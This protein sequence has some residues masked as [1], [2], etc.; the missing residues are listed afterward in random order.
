MSRILATLSV[1]ALSLGLAN[2]ARAEC[3][4]YY[5]FE[6]VVQDSPV[7]VV[8]RVV[9]VNSGS[10]D[11]DVSWVAKGSMTN[12]RVRV[13]DPWANTSNN[14]SL[15]RL[16]A[17]ADIVLAGVLVAEFPR[18]RLGNVRMDANARAQRLG[19]RRVPPIVPR[20]RF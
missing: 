7:V 17:G 9:A 6:Q 15:H 18:D 12:R 1:I 19:R 11:L 4:V 8:G 20:A 14:V 2:S 3:A 10:V 16:N 5:G 13:W